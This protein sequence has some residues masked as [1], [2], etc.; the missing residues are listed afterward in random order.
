M[1]GINEHFFPGFF[2]STGMFRCIKCVSFS[3]LGKSWRTTTAVGESPLFHPRNISE[4][5]S[6]VLWFGIQEIAS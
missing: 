1:A 5:M 3:K 2:R 4:V 6:G